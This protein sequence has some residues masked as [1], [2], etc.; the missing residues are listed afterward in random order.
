MSYFNT[1]AHLLTQEKYYI[2]IRYI[3]QSLQKLLPTLTIHAY[4]VPA[5]H[6]NYTIVRP[7]TCTALLHRE[8]AVQSREAK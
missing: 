3:N 1:V 4:C 6:L 5:R 2:S 7:D 8:L